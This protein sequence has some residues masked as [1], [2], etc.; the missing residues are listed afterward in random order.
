MS[1]FFRA[2]HSGS[3][4]LNPES[5]APQASAL[6][7]SHSP[8]KWPRKNER[9]PLRPSQC[10]KYLENPLRSEFG[11][12]VASGGSFPLNSMLQNTM[13]AAVLRRSGRIEKSPLRLL[14]VS[15]PEPRGKEV[16]IRV[17]ACAVC[18][19]DLHIV[20]G[21]LPARQE[22]LIPGHQVVGEVLGLGPETLRLR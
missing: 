17:E 10:S 20:E 14:E 9:S 15:D 2:T 11:R 19:T 22:N 6:P 13:K 4:E 16:L 12:H 18:R 21:E 1:F 3:R 8:R 5:L 7:L